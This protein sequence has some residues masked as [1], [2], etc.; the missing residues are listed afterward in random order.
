MQHK[1]GLL[2][3]WFFG[4]IVAVTEVDTCVRTVC[5]KRVNFTLCKLNNILKHNRTWDFPGGPVVKTAFQ[6][7]RCGFDPW[8]GT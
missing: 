4:I 2:D 3:P 8:L 5:Q 6:F 7:G 1:G